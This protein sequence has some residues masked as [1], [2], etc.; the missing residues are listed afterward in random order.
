MGR[1][2][3]VEIVVA[4]GAVIE[5]PRS[6]SVLLLCKRLLDV[7]SSLFATAARAVPKQDLDDE[8]GL[9]EQIAKSARIVRSILVSRYDTDAMTQE[10]CD[11]LE[12]E[13]GEDDSLDD[14]RIGRASE[15]AINKIVGDGHGLELKGFK[16]LIY[17]DNHDDGVLLLEH[18]ESRFVRFCVN[19]GVADATTLNMPNIE[20]KEEIDR[21]IH[22]VLRA[23][24][25]EA[26]GDP[27]W[28][29]VVTHS[30]FE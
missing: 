29:L 7:E 8:S 27:G 25:L 9:P 18:F 24:G 11:A 10:E 28:Q 1:E 3:H 4:Y 14:A 17:W 21:N 13:E 5:L 12:E 20:R 30:A 19:A 6:P 23:L 22:Q 26:E 2:S 16:G 15:A